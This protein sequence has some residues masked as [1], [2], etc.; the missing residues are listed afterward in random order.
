MSATGMV[1]LKEL[2]PMTITRSV[3]RAVFTLASMPPLLD[4]RADAQVNAT[5]TFSGRVTDPSGLAIER[6]TVKV[7]RQTTGIEITHLTDSDGLYTIALLKSG[8]Y[9]IQVSAPGFTR[10]IRTNLRLEIQQV[11]QED[12]ELQLGSLEQELTV[13]G[14][15]PLLHTETTE[16]GNVIHRELSEQLPL[17][18]RNFSQLALLVPGAAPGPVGGI[19]TQ[20]NGNE[21]QRAGAEIVAGGARGSFNQFMIDGIDDR[22]QSV[23]TVKVF[24]NLESIEE[25]KV[26]TA[27]YDAQFSGGGAVV[28]VVTRSGGNQV[29]GSAFEFLRNAALNAR[30]FFDAGVPAFQQNQFGLAIGGPVKRNRTFFFG[31]YQGLNVHSSSTSILSQPTAAMRNGDF[32]DYP[33]IIHDPATYN[34]STNSRQPFANN[35]ILPS[36]ID[37]VAMNLLQVMALPNLPGVKNNFRVNNLAVQTQHQ[38]DVR[39]DHAFSQR[40]EMFARVTHGFADIAFP[41]TPVLIE[42][43]INPLAFAQGSATAGSLRLNHAPSL[44]ATWQEIHQFSPNLVNQLALGYT[45]FALTVSPLDEELNLAATLGLQ[46][47]NTGPRSGAMSTLAISG[48]QGT[49]SSNVPEI[50]PQN[51]WQLNDTVSWV[52]GAHSIRGGLSIIHNGF[53]FFQLAAPAGSLSFTGTFTNNPAALSGTGAGFADFLLGLP[54]SS[55]KSVLATG[56]PYVSYTEYGTFLQDQWRVSGKLTINA[57]LRW[58]LFT[59]VQE[60]YNRQSNFL[61]DNSRPEGGRLALAGQNGVSD[62]I[63]ALQRHD[64]SPRLGIAYS[65]NSK[66]VIRAAYGLFYFNEQGT[67]GSSRLFLNY[68]FV[69]QFTVTCSSTV[70]CLSTSTGIPQ[71]ASTNNL[72]AVT[73]QPESN[74]T[75]NVQQWNFTVERQFG[76]SLVVRGAYAGTKGTHLNLNVDENV[77][78]PG[79]GPVAARR[80]F[81]QY[82]TMSSLEPRGPSSYHALQLSAEKRLSASLSFLGAYT[83]GKSLDQG[84]GGN[85]STGESRI[86]IQNPR[87]LA[88]DYGPSNFDIRQRFTLSTLYQVPVGHDRRFLANANRLADGILG[89]WQLGSIVTVQTGMPFSVSMATP[90][91][92]TGTFQ[93]PHRACDG[94]L[95]G[96]RRSLAQW[97]ELS[98]FVAPPVFTFGNTG[99]NVLT[100]PGLATW[101][102]SVNK[103]FRLTERLGLQFRTEFFNLLNHANFGLPNSSIGSAAAGTITTVITNAR[104][105]QFGLRLH[106]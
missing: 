79:A 34:P 83:Y 76:N 7:T 22:D 72:P 63:L 29:H 98:C 77:A 38:Y 69:Q 87:N 10:Q 56:V 4:F 18:G 19:R 37:P 95:T 100:G 94:N 17:N 92:N 82:S 11:A 84:A 30:Q 44:Q 97:Y 86:N 74:L 28:N 1:G 60:R 3:V 41:A 66:T 61:L 89:G 53:G 35:T 103:D 51:T 32:T 8:V 102:F 36:A 62:T 47:A 48:V 104:Q 39:V 58:D 70:P 54:A 31:D 68:P 73:Y 101:D 40:D 6:A 12:F 46:G 81:P 5:A 26:Q 90:T 64:F 67:G 71:S 93:R 85:S 43:R 105:V 9:S 59:P 33:A 96:E 2:C 42:G 65:L 88:A 15:A 16:M 80:P 23:G 57:G 50:V 106:W 78:V 75:P 20:G 49:N 25:F 55:T 21:T 14:K 24:P 13:E 91:S 27:N 45:R 99:R 52:R